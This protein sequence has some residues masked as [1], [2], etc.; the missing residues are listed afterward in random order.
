MTQPRAQIFSEVRRK[1]GRRVPPKV[2]WRPA[3]QLVLLTFLALAC[4]GILVSCG[5][6]EEEAPSPEEVLIGAVQAFF[7]RDFVWLA[8]HAS[9]DW[10]AQMQSEGYSGTT[11]DMI[12]EAFDVEKQLLGSTRPPP[13]GEVS[14]SNEVA[15]EPWAN[16]P[17]TTYT[18]D[19][20][21]STG[22]GVQEGGVILEAVGSD[23]AEIPYR[24]V[25][26]GIEHPGTTAEGG[27][28]A[29]FGPYASQEFLGG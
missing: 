16:Q 6:P 18:F 23:E 9:A 25:A 1:L 10:V 15:A 11:R 17:W 13:E 21:L 4:T 14:V 24:I 7:D 5:Q 3:T 8:Q 2:V 29:L 27:S 28:T 19:F 22:G 20:T 26:M 12:S